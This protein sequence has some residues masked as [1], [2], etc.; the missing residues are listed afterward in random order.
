MFRKIVEWYKRQT[1]F[2]KVSIWLILA[3]VIGIVIRWNYIIGGASR[4]FDFL[5]K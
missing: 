4:G 5:K 1:D 2:T 3:L